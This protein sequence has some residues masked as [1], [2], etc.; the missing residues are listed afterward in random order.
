[1]HH[2]IGIREERRER[3]SS[4]EGECDRARREAVDGRLELLRLG[5]VVQRDGRSVRRR[6]LGRGLPGAPSAEHHDSPTV[7][8]PRH[9]SGGA[10]ISQRERAALHHAPT[11]RVAR[12]TTMPRIPP[13]APITQ[14]RKV[15]CVSAQP[16]R[17]K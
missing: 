16:S 11:L 7:Q 6:E 2:Q 1:M 5:T 4:A 12:K 14:K 17:S 15:I 3:G 9:D 13:M 8:A 10:Q